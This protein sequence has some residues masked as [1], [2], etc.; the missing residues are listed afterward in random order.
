[1]NRI[2]P[3]HIGVLLV[4]I[5]LF[6][7]FKLNDAKNELTEVRQSYK[8]TKEIAL[9]LS[10]LKEVYEEKAKV[11]KALKRVLEQSSLGSA[12]IEQDIKTTSILLR[13]SSM[14]LEALNSL[15]SKLLNGLYTIKAMEI[16]KLSATNV[17]FEMEITW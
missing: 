15:M 6:V 2:N 8:E 5:L 11:Q 12:K 10:G 13:S 17:S 7:L 14:D 1:M 3:L 4:F 9:G 16:K